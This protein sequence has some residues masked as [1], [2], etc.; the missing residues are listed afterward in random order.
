MMF[1]LEWQCCRAYWGHV[2]HSVEVVTI[3]TLLA[4][5]TGYSPAWPVQ[6]LGH[7]V[8]YPQHK[9]SLAP[10]W[11][12]SISTWHMNHTLPIFIPLLWCHFKTT[13][14]EELEMLYFFN[15]F[16]LFWRLVEDYKIIFQPISLFFHFKLH[17][18]SATM[19]IMSHCHSINIRCSFL[20]KEASWY[21]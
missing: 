21:D 16:V 1:H 5:S 14:N 6:S 13:K 20:T 2:Q 3:H 15:K 18:F 4:P 7:V 12:A 11:N 17:V 8:N 10:F 9:T 19:N